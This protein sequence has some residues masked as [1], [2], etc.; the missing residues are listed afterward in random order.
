TDGANRLLNGY[1]YKRLARLWNDQGLRGS[2]GKPWTGEGI[3]QYYRSPRLA[4]YRVHHKT[5]LLGDDGRPVKGL[6]EAILAVEV[7]EGLQAQLA[8]TGPRP[9]ANVYP[10]SGRLRCALCH[11]KLKGNKKS[12]GHDYQC[13]ECGKVAINGPKL[14]ALVIELVIQYLSERE[15]E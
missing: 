15:L 11:S 10:L 12:W 14:D 2:R 6:H 1:G 5:V 9:S 8:I 7:W 13:G 3:K 4:G